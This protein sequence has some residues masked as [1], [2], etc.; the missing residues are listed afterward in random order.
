MKNPKSSLILIALSV[1]FFVSGIV[2]RIVQDQQVA[3]AKK[4]E[5]KDQTIPIKI[6]DFEGDTHIQGAVEQQLQQQQQDSVQRAAGEGRSSD[7]Q[8]LQPVPNGLQ[9]NQ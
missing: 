7:S 6:E 5:V 9:S 3:N 4:Y 2:V 8:L 1:V